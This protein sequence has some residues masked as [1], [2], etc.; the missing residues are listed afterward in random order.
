MG[1]H[2]VDDLTKR[3]QPFTCG[4]QSTEQDCDVASRASQFN[5]MMA[6]LVAPSLVEQ[7]TFQTKELP[8]QSMVYQLGIQ[9]G[10]TSMVFD[11][12]L[13]PIHPLA[14]DLHSFCLNEWPLVE[15]ALSTAMDD[16]ALVLPIILRWFQIETLA[17]FC[18]LGMGQTDH[19]PNFQEIMAIIEWRAY[20]LLPLL[21]HQYLAPA[22]ASR[23]SGTITEGPSSVGLA[24]GV[25][26]S[27]ASDNCQD[28]GQQINNCQLLSTTLA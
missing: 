19:T 6:G 16:S 25:S 27:M 3:L 23:P 15:A 21:P 12:V 17:Y 2:E 1:Y 22:P 26:G 24:P 10:C 28:P 20:H 5:Q 9:L 18:S 7:E 4:F 8:L 13:G 14:Q 11:M